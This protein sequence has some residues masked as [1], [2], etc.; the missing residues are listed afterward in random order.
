MIAECIDCYCRYDT[1]L[2][3]TASQQHCWR[4]DAWISQYFIKCSSALFCWCQ[5]YL[6]F[7]LR[8]WFC[9]CS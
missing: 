1:M 6:R 9:G 5:L 7:V 2:L 8:F 3:I 4:P